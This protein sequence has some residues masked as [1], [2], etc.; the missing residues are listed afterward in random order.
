MDKWMTNCLGFFCLFLL[1]F[2]SSAPAAAMQEQ[3][4]NSLPSTPS[5]QIEDLSG[6][7]QAKPSSLPDAPAPKPA[8]PAKKHENPVHATFEIL[9]RP[10]FFFPELAASRGPL[11]PR[12]KLELAMDESV[13]PS[14][15]LSS[16]LGAGIGQAHD[17]LSGYGQ[18]MS[19]YGKRF[20][21][22]LA[23][24]S[25][26]NFF[27]TF[28]LPTLLHRDPRFFVTLHGGAGYRIGYALSRLVITRKDQGGQAANWPGIIGPLLAESLAN[29]YLP[30]E[31]QT[32]GSTF[33]R[34]GIR[35]GLAG[36]TNV[37][38]EYW[39]TIFRD[40]RIGKIAPGLEPNSNLIEP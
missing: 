15:F 8:G 34:Y 30:V 3:V 28:L 35:L 21:S 23:S 31:E 1:P 14:R 12:Q 10:S 13:A 4:E 18:G 40:L 36:F 20:G 2:G 37:I 24:A 22:S 11:S 26:N 27:G 33:R 32:A 6:S 5:Q 25:S 9:G 38:R 29:S 7:L 17:A 19:G 39:P 16:A